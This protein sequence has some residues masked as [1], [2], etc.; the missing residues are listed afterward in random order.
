MDLALV[1]DFYTCSQYNFE[2]TYKSFDNLL[3]LGAFFVKRFCCLVLI[4]LQ[5]PKRRQ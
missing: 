5:L 2:L 4:R 1:L 3:P